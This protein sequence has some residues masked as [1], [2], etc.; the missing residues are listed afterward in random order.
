MLLSLYLSCL[1]CDIQISQPK[2]RRS[3]AKPDLGVAYL[4]APPPQEPLIE[5]SEPE[6]SEEEVPVRKERKGKKKVGVD[7]QLRCDAC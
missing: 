5:E 3:S 6:E 4:Q 1:A 2:R 7:V